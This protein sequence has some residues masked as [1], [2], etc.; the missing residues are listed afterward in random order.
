MGADD[1]SSPRDKK[2]IKSSLGN[3]FNMDSKGESSKTS[4]VKN[5]DLKTY[6]TST[7]SYS[8]RMDKNPRKL[9]HPFFGREAFGD[10]AKFKMGAVWYKVNAKDFSGSLEPIKDNLDSKDSIK[11]LPRHEDLGQPINLPE[12]TIP[13]KSI[14][15]LVDKTTSPPTAY[16]ANLK[17]AYIEPYS[18]VVVEQSRRFKRN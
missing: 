12:N 7:T 9:P 5:V 10:V 18:R 8:H 16:G 14:N 4:S 13:P 11:S 15:G 6:M 1:I 2:V 3:I 17:E